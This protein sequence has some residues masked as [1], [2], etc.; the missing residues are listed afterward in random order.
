VPPTL[1]SIWCTV[2]VNPL[3]GSQR[4]IASAV[5]KAR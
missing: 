2:Q 5:V 4:A 1:E 3:G